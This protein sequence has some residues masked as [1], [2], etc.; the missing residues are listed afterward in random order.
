MQF[1]FSALKAHKKL[2]L[3]VPPPP[4]SFAGLNLAGVQQQQDYGC[5]KTAE[6]WL[7]AITG[8][9]QQ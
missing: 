5:N 8:L 6:T 7:M 9:L 2:L 1:L 3:K 4:N